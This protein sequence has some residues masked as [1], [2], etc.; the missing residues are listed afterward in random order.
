MS[1]PGILRRRPLEIGRE[2]R[3]IANGNSA[4]PVSH[5]G[6]GF[7]IHQVHERIGRRFDPHRFNVA[8]EIH[9]L[10]QI[11][12]AGGDLLA[13]QDA[14]EEAVRAA[15]KVVVDQDGVACLEHH[16]HGSLGGHAGSESKSGRAAFERGETGLQHLARRPATRNR[17][18]KRR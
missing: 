4:V 8:G 14:F 17:V 3:V 6:H 12:V 15:I 2:E 5:G 13:A 10:A 7:Q 9:R 16:E 11:H 18:G 1:Y